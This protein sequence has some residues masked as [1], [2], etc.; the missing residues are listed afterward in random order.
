MKTKILGYIAREINLLTNNE[1]HRQE[2]WL[3]FLEGNS[4]FTFQEYLIKITNDEL[5]NKTIK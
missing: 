5:N 1:D 4:P 2:L 3:Y